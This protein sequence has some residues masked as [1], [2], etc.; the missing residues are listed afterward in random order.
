MNNKN[1]K[2]KLS[3]EAGHLVLRDE[4]GKLFWSRHWIDIK[5]SY[6]EDSY[7]S[8]GYVEVFIEGDFS[9]VTKSDFQEECFTIK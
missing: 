8:G 2:K 4:D 1:M 5:G 3:F 6:S 7:D 9:V